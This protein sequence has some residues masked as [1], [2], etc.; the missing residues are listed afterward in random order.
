MGV[1]RLAKVSSIASGKS[2]KWLWGV[3]AWGRIPRGSRAALPHL[4]AA[5]SSGG[6]GRVIRNPTPRISLR[7][8]SNLNLHQPST[9][10]FAAA[11]LF[12]CCPCQAESCGAGDGI[13]WGQDFSFSIVA[14]P[15]P[16]TAVGPAEP[17]IDVERDAV[18]LDFSPHVLGAVRIEPNSRSAW[19]GE[20]CPA[21]MPLRA[22]K[23]VA[24]HR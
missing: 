1:Q 6:A 5:V 16:E 9:T 20:R 21:D 15:F 12:S 14:G 11:P 18:R 23:I 13:P 3:G 7:L 22:A 19:I 2:Q 17:V 8:F 10:S 24:A 4:L